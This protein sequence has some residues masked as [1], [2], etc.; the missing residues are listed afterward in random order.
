MLLLA[1]QILWKEKRKRDEKNVNEIVSLSRVGM[2][3]WIAL[4]ELFDAVAVDRLT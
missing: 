4:E 2:A 3:G 1:L